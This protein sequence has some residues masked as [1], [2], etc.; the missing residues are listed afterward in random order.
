MKKLF[1]DP[2]TRLRLLLAFGL[3]GIALMLGIALL[4]STSGEVRRVARPGMDI[5]TDL[6]RSLDTLLARYGV[7]R[8]SVTTW[9]VSTPDRRFSRVEQRVFVRPQFEILSFNHDLA[10]LV[11]PLGVR[12]IGTER[13]KEQIVSL[14]LVLDGLTIRSVSFVTRI[15]GN[16]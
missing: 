8:G 14:H 9:R 13:V 2:V 3:G 16:R 1:T 11:A 7:D 15:G 5:S 6:G 10:G 4:S 12:V